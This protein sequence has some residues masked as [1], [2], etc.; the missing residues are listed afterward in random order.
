MRAAGR[1][2][3]PLLCAPWNVA[4]SKLRNARTG[5][6]SAQATSV[7]GVR[8]SPSPRRRHHACEGSR[9]W[10]GSPFLG[11]RALARGHTCA[12]LR[13]L[14]RVGALDLSMGRTS[15]RRQFVVS[16]FGV[17]ACSRAR[18]AAPKAYSTRAPTSVAEIE[19]GVGGRVGVFAVDTGSGRQ[20]AHRADERFAM[21]STFKWVL[22]AAL[23]ANA[24]RAQLS[25]DERVGY[26]P[27]DL[28]E[29]APFAREH[30]GE[31]SATV[32]ALARA[33]VTV[34]DNTAANLLLAKIGGP[35]ELTRFVRSMGDP[36]T[37]LDRTEPTLNSNEPGDLRD[38]TSPRAMAGLMRRLL[39]GD[40]L[41]HA[42]RER[43][44]SWL[45][46][47]ETGKGRLRAGFPANWIVGDKT[48]T[49][50]HSATNDVAIAVPPARA[51]IL[52]AAYMSEGTAAP[53]ALQ[54]AQ[55]DVGRLV[56]R[57]FSL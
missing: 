57:E 5:L 32:E 26:G 41:S 28:L 23:L 9:S 37:R 6:R 45:R 2:G 16:V 48:G 20:V 53:A 47:C 4:E 17:M 34:S 42:S 15:N 33:A 43:L 13:E 24:D 55:A 12:F 25:L 38:T 11:S 10:R 19:A 39:C 35:S 56:A 22:A 27:S 51:P 36:V 21:C 18:L 50:A 1:P 29:Y 44:L 54:A 40:T 14:A 8:R 30:V 52:V 7:S 3:A 49:G 31:G 46:D